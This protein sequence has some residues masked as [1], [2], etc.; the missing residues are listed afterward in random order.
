VKKEIVNVFGASAWT[1]GLIFGLVLPASA[2]YGQKVEGYYRSNGTYVQPHYRSSP[3]QTQRDN[4]STYGNQN[5]YTGQ[6][7]TR[8]CG[9]T[10]SCY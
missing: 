8:K 9:L 5:P 7:G 1:A 10:E 3:N 6:Y 4:Y 2:Q